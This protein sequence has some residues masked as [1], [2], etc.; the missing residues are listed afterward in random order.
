MFKKRRIHFYL[1]LV[2]LLALFLNIG[3]PVR[4]GL[5]RLSLVGL[6]LIVLAGLVLLTLVA[7]ILCFL[8]ANRWAR[9]LI[10]CERQPNA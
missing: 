8:P 6:A 5:T 7:D 4:T 9:A 2:A 3:F 10:K 1:W